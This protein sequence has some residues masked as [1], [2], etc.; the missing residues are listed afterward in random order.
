MAHGDGFRA[1]GGPDGHSLEL[2]PSGTCPVIL[3]GVP[4]ARRALAVGHKMSPRLVGAY[5]LHQTDS[6]LLR[7]I[8]EALARVDCLEVQTHGKLKL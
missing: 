2:S 8:E 6:R 5:P 4:T 7:A 1:V 3:R